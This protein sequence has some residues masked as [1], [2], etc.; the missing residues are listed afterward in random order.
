M[1]GAYDDGDPLLLLPFDQ[2]QRY[3][4]AADMVHELG[5]P[6]GSRVIDVGGAPGSIEQFLPDHETVVV[7]VEGP[8][9]GCFVLGSGAGLP[10]RSSS[11][12]AAIALDTLEHVPPDHRA[13]FLAELRRAADVVIVSAPFADPQV[14][15]AEAALGE[16]VTQRFGGFAT[17]AEHAEHGLPR[18]EETVQEFEKD[19]WSVATLPSGYL[20]RWLAGML[21]HH[22]LLATGVTEL[23]RLHAYYN[24]TVSPL[25]CREPAYRHVV[26][27][28]RA[29]PRTRL[30]GAVAEF[31]SEGDTPEALTLLRSI[32][33]AV[34]AQ[35][36]GGVL[37]S[38]EI[39]A[40]EAELAAAR[41]HAAGMD[42]VVAD[43]DGHV[44]ELRNDRARLFDENARLRAQIG[45]LQRTLTN[46]VLRRIKQTIVG[47]KR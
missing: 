9:H 14:E 29:I 13:G 22:E 27:A 32:A 25:D 40:L 23:S 4:V 44:S 38:A 42:R 35:R 2:Y 17:L 26:V 10:F 11:F 45:D 30:T 8:F 15:L 36:L 46:R 1:T 37:R 28:A 18:L 19:D 43:R 31:R 24:A 21:L 5:V 47:R 12:A 3:R 7:D 6:G 41:D 16:F 33:S 39:T 20:P 34:F